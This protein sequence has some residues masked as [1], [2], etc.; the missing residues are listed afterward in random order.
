VTSPSPVPAPPRRLA[1]MSAWV[2]AIAEH[3]RPED[4]PIPQV[5]VIPTLPANQQDRD[6]AFDDAQDR[7]LGLN[8]MCVYTTR[9]GRR[10]HLFPDGGC[11][12]GTGMGADGV[13]RDINTLQVC[14]PCQAR[15][16]RENVPAPAAEATD[17]PGA[18][19]H[20]QHQGV[21]EQVERTVYM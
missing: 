10:V 8:I 7:G 3:A 19:Y 18:P 12:A 5:P 11:L 15:F 2:N 6:N 1:D 20:Q 4:V 17:G 16:R 21:D 14:W 9:F 13:T